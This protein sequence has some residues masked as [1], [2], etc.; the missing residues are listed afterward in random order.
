[1]KKI[2][3]IFSLL[4]V[5][6]QIFAQAT[7]QI[8]GCPYAFTKNTEYGDSGKDIY[9]LQQ[10][11]N[12]DNRTIIASAG[13][14]SPGM[15]SN[16][17]GKGT[18]EALKRF[19][20]LFIEY[21]GTADGKFSGRTREMLQSICNGKESNPKETANNQN[22]KQTDPKTQESNKTKTPLEI[23]LALNT[24]VASS[25]SLIKVFLVS[26]K[27]LTT[28]S[29]DMFIVDGGTIGEVRKLSK[30]EYFVILTPNEDAKTIS[31]QIEADRVEDIDGM[32]NE[33]ASNEIT[34]TASNNNASSTRSSIL[35]GTVD[36][37]QSNLDKIL[38][39]LTAG[40]PT[41]RANPS[42]QTN[43]TV[44]PNTTPNSDNGSQ[45][46]GFSQMLAGLLGGLGRQQG[47][48]GQQQNGSG[49]GGGADNNGSGGGMDIGN[50]KNPNL[51][52]TLSESEIPS[53]IL[54]ACRPKYGVDVGGSCPN[55]E[56]AV[57]EL[58][59]TTMEACTKLGGKRLSSNSVVRRNGC[60]K[61]KGAGENSQ[62]VLGKAI[63]IN[64]GGL[65]SAEKS[66]VF[67]VFKQHGFKGVGCYG[68]GSFVHLDLGS[69]RKWGPNGS[70][71]TW[72]FG[73]ECPKELLPIF[74]H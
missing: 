10:I 34:L 66:T 68:P 61:G 30:T 33:N 22:I 2:F 25:I 50:N 16:Y 38:S 15:E 51:N 20:A 53:N 19:Q 18:R 40:L 14:G 64:M 74:G 7:V 1:M 13:V 6:T 60:E 48:Q 62:H 44:Q 27:E 17:F 35:S 73:K 63:D 9:I 47:Q 42:T 46:N 28:V 65:S 72:N 56:D 12:S 45:N 11:L 8:P 36:S 57:A 52:K 70:N 37:L 58:K 5:S 54:P 67:M 3:F 31:I 26:N 23:R 4:I 24:N 55:I 69:A 49:G 32:K 43:Q 41:N 39:G 29:S 59:L 21:I 71:S